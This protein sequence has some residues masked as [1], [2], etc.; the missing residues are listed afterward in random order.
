MGCA[1]EARGERGG[2]ALIYVR[3]DDKTDGVVTAAKIDMK[4]RKVLGEPVTIL[5]GVSVH[6]N[7]SVEA[8]RSTNGTLV[9]FTG[10]STSRLT[11]VDMHGTTPAMTLRPTARTS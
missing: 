5:S 8:A 10:A 7:G 9:Y 1:D 4:Q 6:G 11:S 3:S 2:A